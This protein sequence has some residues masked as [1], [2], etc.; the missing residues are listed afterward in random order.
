MK[1][2]KGDKDVTVLKREGC[3]KKTC[4]EGCS[5][6]MIITDSLLNTTMIITQNIHG[7]IALKGSLLIDDMYEHIQNG[8]CLQNDCIYHNKAM[9]FKFEQLAHDTKVEVNI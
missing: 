8:S 4:V 5:K 2:R 7:T 9:E 3:S 1:K 6:K